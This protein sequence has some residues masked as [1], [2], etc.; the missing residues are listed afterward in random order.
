VARTGDQALMFR[1]GQSWAATGDTGSGVAQR[2]EEEAHMTVSMDEIPLQATAGGQW[3]AM[4]WRAVVVWLVPFVGTGPL[5]GADGKPVVSFAV[6]KA[7]AVLLLIGV[8]L[9][10]RR[11]PPLGWRSAQTAIVYVGISVLLDLIVLVAVLEMSWSVWA[12]T[13]LPVYLVVPVML[14]IRVPRRAAAGLN[15]S[16]PADPLT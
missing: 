5:I 6:F 16:P 15:G 4:L 3:R 2:V 8:L 9:L 13:V 10:M 11:W 7:V 1:V 12:L 14:R